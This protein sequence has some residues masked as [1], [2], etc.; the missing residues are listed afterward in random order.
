MAINLTNVQTPH[1]STGLDS[2][3]KNHLRKQDINTRK[4]PPPH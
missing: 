4:P 1:R 2:D 3:A